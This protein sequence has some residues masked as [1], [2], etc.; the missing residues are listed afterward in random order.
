MRIAH[1]V[2]GMK[3]GGVETMLVNIINEQ[4]KTEEVRLFIIN[5]FVDEFIVDKISS[6]CRIFKLNRKPGDKNPL[7]IVKL[8]YWLWR[9][10]PDII[11]VHSYQVS[12][13]ILG[14]WNI[15]RTIHNTGNHPD[16]YP[17]MKALYAISDIVK[18]V[19]VKQGFPNVKTVYNGINIKDIKSKGQYD[20]NNGIYQIVQVSRLDV[21]QK[22]QDILLNALGILYHSYGLS[23]YNLHLVGTGDSYAMLKE[24]VIKLGLEK[25]VIFEGLKDQ[26]FIF[27][28]L[29]EFDLFIQPSRYEGFG[30]T[31]AEAMAAKLPVLVSNIEGPME[32]IGNGKYGMSFESENVADLADKLRIVL[33]GGYDYSLIEK[34]YQHVCDEYDVR[35]TARKY[36][37]EYKQIVQ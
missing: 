27:N 28:H 2:W 6:L 22:G 23:N 31:V 20:V 34:A 7:K 36:I 12:K 25:F 29:C 1:V 14:H 8:N 21:S 33:Q 17:K 18:A 10:R 32:I 9:Y 5:D 26:E 30:I 13:L 11:H 16:E 15:V 4:V 37:S 24:L 35:N 3:T 19:T